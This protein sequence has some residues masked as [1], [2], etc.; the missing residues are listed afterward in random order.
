MPLAQLDGIEIF[1]R[2]DGPKDGTPL[3]LIMGFAAQYIAWPEVFVEG[4][5]ARGFRVIRFDNRDVGES[6]SLEGRPPSVT[7]A[8][9]RWVAGL[10]IG[11]PYTLSDMA[12]D[13]RGLL[14]HLGVAAAHLVGVSM[15]G[16]IAQTFAIE[17]PKRALSLTSIM[18]HPGSRRGGLGKPHALKA[19]LTRKTPRTREE[20]GEAMADTFEI[21][22]SP[23]LV[24]R[25]YMVELGRRG[26]DRGH[27][28][29]GNVRQLLAILSAPDRRKQL[30]RLRLPTVVIHGSADPL[31][32]VIGGRQ[33]AKAIP[34][35]RLE[36]I[37]GMG[38]DLNAAFFERFWAAI[39]RVARG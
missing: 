28:P 18:S 22:G 29:R 39:E 6:T 27:N 20:A 4:L 11:A 25:E 9:A 23:G 13:A 10:S 34:G 24:N 32:P 33:T 15:G 38:H 30:R 35:A 17:H 5:V 19:L 16:M 1:Y 31:V 21:I 7:R 8:I 2:I 36:I 14:D 37:E 26:F 12:A 3:L